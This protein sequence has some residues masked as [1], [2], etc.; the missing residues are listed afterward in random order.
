MRTYYC[1]E[2]GCPSFPPNEILVLD[3]PP[4]DLQVRQR[5]ER[6]RAATRTEAEEL[7]RRRLYDERLEAL[8]A[9]AAKDGY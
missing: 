3:R 7:A 2:M 4:V 8:K 5:C 9:S 6:V 1:I